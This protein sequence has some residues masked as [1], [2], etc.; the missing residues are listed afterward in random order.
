M[1]KYKKFQVL[2][3]QLNP[4]PSMLVN[5]VLSA[6]DYVR[7]FE[8]TLTI[9]APHVLQQTYVFQSL[10]EWEQMRNVVVDDVHI[11][12]TPYVT[13]YFE[14]GV[15]SGDVDHPQPREVDNVPTPLRKNLNAM[16]SH[17]LMKLFVTVNSRLYDDDIPESDLNH[18]ERCSEIITIVSGRLHVLSSDE[19]NRWIGVIQ[20]KLSALNL[21]DED[22]HDKFVSAVVSASYRCLGYPVPLTVVNVEGSN[23]YELKSV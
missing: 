19:V 23:Q 6:P 22:G 3:L 12:L 2:E 11:N 1:I 5:C 14:G 15:L 20:G 9:N 10:H 13:Y 16:Y 7:A 18:L 17:I 8:L 4:T 21:I